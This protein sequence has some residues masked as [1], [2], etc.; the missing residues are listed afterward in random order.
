MGHKL[1]QSRSISK[2]LGPVDPDTKQVI[3]FIKKNK[4]KEKLT[5]DFGDGYLLYQSIKNSESIQF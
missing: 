4:Y 1:K 2:Y 5:L 3:K